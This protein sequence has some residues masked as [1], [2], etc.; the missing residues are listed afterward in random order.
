MSIFKTPNIAPH[1]HIPQPLLKRIHKL[2]IRNRLLYNLQCHASASQPRRNTTNTAYHIPLRN[3][4]ERLL[5]PRPQRRDENI[6]GRARTDQYPDIPRQIEA[7]A[8]DGHLSFFHAGRERDEDCR[9]HDAAPQ[10][11]GGD[12][13][14][15]PD[16]G[17]ASPAEDEEEIGKHLGGCAE[18][19][20]G[21]V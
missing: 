8:R 18:E 11:A 6:T 2:Q 12:V 21:L 10:A 16:G 20:E 9:V 5:Q 4:P 19:G 13:E 14:G 7:R 17:V 1:N 3:F 15:L